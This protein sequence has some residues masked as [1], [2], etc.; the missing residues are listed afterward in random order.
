MRPYVV[1]NALDRAYDYY[2]KL[3]SSIRELY[4]SVARDSGFT[5]ILA[6]LPMYA[7]MHVALI[8]WTIIQ[9]RQ[10]I[11]SQLGT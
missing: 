8:L 5:D 10:S 3:F 6:D 4:P 1:E 11:T 7:A 9:S 2:L